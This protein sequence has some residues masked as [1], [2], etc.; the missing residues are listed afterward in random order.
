[1]PIQVQA[2]ASNCSDHSSTSLIVLHEMEKPD[3]FGLCGVITA[4]V[5]GCNT[6][7]SRV[8]QFLTFE[9]STIESASILI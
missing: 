7:G 6:R 1:M 4:V 5:L 9:M 3:S 8:F 2:L